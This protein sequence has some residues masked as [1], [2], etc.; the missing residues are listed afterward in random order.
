MLKTIQTPSAILVMTNLR[1]ERC[2]IRPFQTMPR[3]VRIR[4]ATRMYCMRE[5]IVLAQLT[6]RMKAGKLAMTKPETRAATCNLQSKCEAQF[7]PW[8][9]DSNQSIGLVARS[10][11][12][13]SNSAVQIDDCRETTS[14]GFE[15]SDHPRTSSRQGPLQPCRRELSAYS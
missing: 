8:E 13:A 1:A 14:S 10:G 3:I 15:E 9:G 7:D 11:V 4:L 6:F 12:G 2:P 5:T